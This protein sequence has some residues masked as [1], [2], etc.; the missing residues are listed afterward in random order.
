MAERAFCVKAMLFSSVTGVFT[1][2]LSETVGYWLSGDF[3]DKCV[4]NWLKLSLT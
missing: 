3:V 1:A 4:I 2:N